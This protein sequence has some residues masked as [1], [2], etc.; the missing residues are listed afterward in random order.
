MWSFCLRIERFAIPVHLM[1][2]HAL[3]MRCWWHA[4][5]VQHGSSAEKIPMKTT[6]KKNTP[7]KPV[8][9]H[10]WTVAISNQLSTS[11]CMRCVHLDTEQKKSNECNVPCEEES[12]RERVEKTTA[13]GI[14][15]VLF[16]DIVTRKGASDDKTTL[17]GEHAAVCFSARRDND[18]LSTAMVC[19]CV[20]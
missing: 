20:T 8:Q 10:K 15:C 18:S 6:E 5:S 4:W 14:G 19:L 7:L 12:Q 9:T 11:E 17:I 13:V 16:G 2:E 1:H 3:M